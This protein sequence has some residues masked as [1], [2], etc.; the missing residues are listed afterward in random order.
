MDI[1]DSIEI[2]D[3]KFRQC[4]ICYSRDEENIKEI[5]FNGTVISMCKPCREYLLK[6]LI[7]ELNAYYV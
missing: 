5:S 3:A 1:N 4:N 6:A 2:K 7:D